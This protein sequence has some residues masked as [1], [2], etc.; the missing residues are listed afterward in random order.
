MNVDVGIWPKLSR[1]VVV[2]LV[3]AVVVGVVVWYLPVIKHNEAFRKEILHLNAEIK[4]QE[5]LSRQLDSATKALKND[6]KTLE[7]VA[8]EKLGYVKP[9]ETM[10]RFEEPSTNS[11]PQR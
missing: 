10:I 11:V 1:I 8:R 9:G 2:L 5:D 4:Q 3:L 7:R 6:P